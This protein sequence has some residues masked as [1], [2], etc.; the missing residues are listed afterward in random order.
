MELQYPEPEEKP[1][2]N[3][4]PPHPSS[5]IQ[6]EV[7]RKVAKRVKIETRHTTPPTIWVGVIANSLSA[8]RAHELS[9]A[10]L[11]IVSEHNVTGVDVAFGESVA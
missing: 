6:T 10:I 3:V 8:E 11:G 2:V 4:P 9:D 1:Q 5:E 7:A